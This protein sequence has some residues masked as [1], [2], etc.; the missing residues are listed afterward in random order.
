VALGLPGDQLMDLARRGRE[1]S[2]EGE[3]IVQDAVLSLMA[4]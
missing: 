2:A 1:L 3:N 4:S